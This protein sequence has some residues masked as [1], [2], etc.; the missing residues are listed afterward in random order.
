MHIYP[1][2]AP[3]YLHTFSLLMKEYVVKRPMH[4][5]TNDTNGV[6]TETTN[7]CNLTHSQNER[8]PEMGI[9]QGHAVSMPLWRWT[10]SNELKIIVIY[11]DKIPKTLS[12][13]PW[14]IRGNPFPISHIGLLSDFSHTVVKQT[15]KPTHQRPHDEPSRYHCRPENIWRSCVTL[16]QV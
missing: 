16:M 5:A 13:L 1:H 15:D 7:E 11:G 4:T 14:A 6:G 9:A 2:R 10:N 12:A 3:G 8:L